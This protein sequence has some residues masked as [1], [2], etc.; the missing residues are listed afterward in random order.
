MRQELSKLQPA[1]KLLQRH[2]RTN[3]RMLD[4]VGS[5]RGSDNIHDTERSHKRVQSH[6]S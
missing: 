3:A 1:S 2:W 4:T 6:V 5:G